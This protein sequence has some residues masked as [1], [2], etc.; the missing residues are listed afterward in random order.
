[1][2]R[3]EIIREIHQ[4]PYAPG[5]AIKEIAERPI[6]RHGED[7]DR[8]STPHWAGFILRRKLGL[9]TEKRHGNYM[10]AAAQGP[11]IERVN[12]SNWFHANSRKQ[13]CMRPDSNIRFLRFQSPHPMDAPLDHLRR[14]H[15]RLIA[16][17]FLGCNASADNG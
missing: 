7:F 2:V 4:E 10:I 9:K 14:P 17:G 5:L 12:P 8:K 11:N 6:A 13:S 1:M 15:G 3:L 16:C